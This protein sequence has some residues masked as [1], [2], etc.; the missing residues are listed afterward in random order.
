M[1]S[2]LKEVHDVHVLNDGVSGVVVQKYVENFRRK[3]ASPHQGFFSSFF[4]FPINISEGNFSIL[5]E[6]EKEK[7]VFPS[8]QSIFTKMGFHTSPQRQ[9]KIGYCLGLS[10]FGRSY[11]RSGARS[12]ESSFCRKQQQEGWPAAHAETAS[13]CSRMISSRG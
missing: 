4:F 12:L 9:G 3:I 8:P 1:L 10:Y 2:Y 6:N 5:S 7:I 11:I 13:L